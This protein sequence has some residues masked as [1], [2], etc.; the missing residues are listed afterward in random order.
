MKMNYGAMVGEY[1]APRPGEVVVG[2]N[3]Q[4][5]QQSLCKIVRVHPMGEV[6]SRPLTLR[7]RI[8]FLVTGH[9]GPQ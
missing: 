7:E 6:L 1:R 5:G 9:F 2:V 4:T 3:R 8:H